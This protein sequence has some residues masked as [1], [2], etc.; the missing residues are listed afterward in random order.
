MKQISNGQG[1][2]INAGLD[3]GTS[4]ITCAIGQNSLDSKNVKL[5]GISTIPSQGMRQGVIIHRDKLIES[6]EHVISDTERMANIKI[7]NIVVSITGEHIRSLNTQAAIPLTK[8]NGSSSNGA[9]RAINANDVFQVLNLAQAVSLPVDRDI[10]H[11]LPQEYLVD[12]LK[13]IKNPVGMNGRRLE[14]RVHLV[15]AGTTAMTNSCE[16]C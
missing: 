6:I 11:T 8:V 5:L 7:E 13:D 3:I 10:L 15:T 1:Q 16:M 14:G 9:D 12:T 2:K 4:N